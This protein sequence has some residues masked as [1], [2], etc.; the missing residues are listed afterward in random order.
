MAG[1]RSELSV[2]RYMCLNHMPYQLTEANVKFRSLIAINS[3]LNCRE[4]YTELA[5]RAA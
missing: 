2:S 5:G 4:F 3:L 1:I